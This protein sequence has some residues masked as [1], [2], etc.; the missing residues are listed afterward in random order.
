MALGK[1][2]DLAL[3]ER[4]LP[5]PLL[6]ALKHVFARAPARCMLVGGTALSGFYAGHRRSDDLDLFT[7][8]EDDH[9]AAVLAMRSLEDIGATVAVRQSSRLYFRALCGLDG[10]AFTADVAAAPSL[11][12]LAEGVVVHGIRVADFETLL[13]LKGAALV[14]RCAEKDLYDVLWLLE[15]AP[16]L[17]AADLASAAQ[18]LDVG[19]TPENL[20]IGLLGARIE[21]QSCGFSLDP[22]VTAKAIHRQLMRFRTELARALRK[23]AKG[24]AQE[25]LG[26]LVQRVRRLAGL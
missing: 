4:V 11:F 9:A 17:T 20:L 19:A 26:E 6:R 8:S 13:A 21:E 18:R 22:A 25:P 5:G 16:G 10:H 7:D 12:R 3:A 1:Q 15:H 23:L 24:G 2:P 14:S